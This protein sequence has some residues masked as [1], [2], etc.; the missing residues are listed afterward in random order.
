MSAATL[1]S[2]T[3]SA[4][5]SLGAGRSTGTGEALDV[6]KGDNWL[7]AS[8]D[9]VA[10]DSTEEPPPVRMEPPLVAPP[11]R[12]KARR[13]KILQQ[14]EGVVR[15]VESDSF[16]AELRDLTNSSNPPEYAEIELGDITPADKPLLQ[17]GA[18]LYWTIGYET[19]ESGQVLRI[20]EM[21]VRRL[22]RWTRKALDLAKRKGEKLM[23]QFRNDLSLPRLKN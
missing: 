7:C 3:T 4:L 8:S 19:R 14:W 9:E 11:R 5:E 23:E 2:A 18:V 21:R 22:P 1:E 12:A 16:E 15:R 6:P 13:L 20:S 10:E 17:V